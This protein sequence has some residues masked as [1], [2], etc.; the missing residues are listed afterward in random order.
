MQTKLELFIA[1]I[2]KMK[3]APARSNYAERLPSKEQ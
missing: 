2:F 3:V 1:D